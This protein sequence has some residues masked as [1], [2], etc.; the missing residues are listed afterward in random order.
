MAVDLFI[1]IVNN[2]IQY[3]IRTY[4]H[5]QLLHI[6]ICSVPRQ[7]IAYVRYRNVLQEYPNTVHREIKTSRNNYTKI[8][9]LKIL[10]NSVFIAAPIIMVT[11]EIVSHHLA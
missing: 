5:T 1:R 2:K 3:I 11:V 4:I 7:D 9:P 8:N 6:H 10:H